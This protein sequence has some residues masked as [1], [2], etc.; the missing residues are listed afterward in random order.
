M[1]GPTHCKDKRVVRVISVVV[2]AVKTSL[3]WNVCIFAVCNQS[4]SCQLASDDSNC[5]SDILESSMGTR[6]TCVQP[7]I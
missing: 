2:V 3:P 6:E 7:A 1:E 5:T 4:S